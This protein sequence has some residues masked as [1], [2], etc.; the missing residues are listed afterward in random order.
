[1]PWW[2]QILIPMFLVAAN[3]FSCKYI[4]T[5]LY[6]C[7]ADMSKWSKENFQNLRKE[8]EQFQRKFPKLQQF[9]LKDK[10]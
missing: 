9:S 5:K 8:A 3:N 10:R 1:V 2:S 4:V 7:A 6:K